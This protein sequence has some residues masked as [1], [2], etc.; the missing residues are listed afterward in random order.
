MNRV[1]NERALSRLIQF[2]A[3]GYLAPRIY[4]AKTDPLGNHLL[5]LH[6]R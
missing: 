1:N 3:C 2:G 6:V 5:L 4:A